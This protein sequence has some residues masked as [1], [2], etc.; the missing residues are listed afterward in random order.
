[1]RKDK[2]FTYPLYLTFCQLEMVFHQHHTL[3][4]HRKHVYLLGNMSNANETPV[5][6]DT[7]TNTKTYVQGSKSVLV[8]LSNQV[9]KYG[10][11]LLRA[12]ELFR[13]SRDSLL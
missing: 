3:N 12:I 10:M 1:M 8:L 9:R 11:H 6:V 13:S 5:F 7:L 4:M 2:I